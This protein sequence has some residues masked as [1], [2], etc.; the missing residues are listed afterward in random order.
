M[1]SIVGYPNTMP[2]EINKWLPK[3]P[4]NIVVTAEE[5][6]Y[7]IGRDMENEG[8]EH[9]DVEMELLDVSLI[10][11]D[12]RWFKRLP[13]NHLETYEYF[14]K[15]LKIIWATKKDSIM[16]MT[17]FTQ[18]K[19]KKNET[20]SEIDTRFDKLHGQIP[21]YLCPSYV[22]VCLLYVNAFEGKFG[23]ILRDKKPT[24]LAQAK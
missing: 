15:L 9:E 14:A 13:D 5:H 4:R 20:V 16:L 2:K 8:V 24:T 22:V 17:Q 21:K 23:F 18:L 19:K 12:Q 6:L 1:A 11:Y 10:E 7:A 3:F